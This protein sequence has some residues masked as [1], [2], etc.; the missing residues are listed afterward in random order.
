[1]LMCWIGSRLGMSGLAIRSCMAARRTTSFMADVGAVA[2]LQ[3]VSCD[4]VGG[5]CD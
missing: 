3:A 1:M 5:I 4:R 2:P